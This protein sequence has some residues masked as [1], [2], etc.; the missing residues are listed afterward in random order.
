MIHAVVGTIAAGCVLSGFIIGIMLL[1]E[2][3]NKSRKR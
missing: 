2:N 1:F 3:S